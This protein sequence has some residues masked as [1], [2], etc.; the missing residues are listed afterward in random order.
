MDAM[1]ISPGDLDDPRI[2]ALLGKHL[3]MMRAASPPDSV[4][5]LDL[6]GLKNPAI[7]F[8]AAWD[9]EILQ[10]VG[11]LKTLDASHGEIKSMHTTASAR[12]RG[13]G[14][15][16]LTHIITTAKARGM[17][18][19]SLETGSMDAFIPARTLY[20]RNGFTLCPPF[21]DY[22]DDPASVCMTR[23]V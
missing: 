3:E 7:S 8:W 17:T 15:A 16:M 12:G 19:L 13:I 21:G 5:A 6:S 18:R 14:Q 4:H 2:I 23:E 11:A 20:A 22:W 1:N 10:G 9:R